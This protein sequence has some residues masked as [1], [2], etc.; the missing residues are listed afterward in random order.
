MLPPVALPP[1][2]PHTK[3]DPIYA[4]EVYMVHGIE[5]TLDLE[6][7]SRGGFGT[8]EHLLGEAQ[9]PNGNAGP[10]PKQV[11][12]PGMA[13]ALYKGRVGL[14]PLLPQTEALPD[15]SVR[16]KGLGSVGHGGHV[17]H[18]P[19][20][21]EAPPGSLDT[22]GGSVFEIPPIH[23]QGAPQKAPKAQPSPAY[24]EIASEEL[25][26]DVVPLKA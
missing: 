12:Q 15:I 7:Q 6:M 5:L 13:G 4:A 21:T 23:R 3:T 18:R 25:H 11:H 2:A 10:Q 26:I 17:G 22:V 8:L 20:A 1:T 14:S 24:G 9:A 19:M 16:S